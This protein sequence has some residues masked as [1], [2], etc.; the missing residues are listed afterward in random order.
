LED[1]NPAFEISKPMM[2]RSRIDTRSLRFAI[3]VAITSRHTAADVAPITAV[4]N[5]RALLVL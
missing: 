1:E 5:V 3:I 4:A 2:M